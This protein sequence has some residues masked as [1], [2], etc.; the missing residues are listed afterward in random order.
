[1]HSRVI[2]ALTR[3]QAAAG[4]AW[5]VQISL[6]RRT[7]SLAVVRGPSRRVEGA[8]GKQPLVSPR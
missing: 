8:G 1:M 6:S 3:S 2:K 7:M 5:P 4:P